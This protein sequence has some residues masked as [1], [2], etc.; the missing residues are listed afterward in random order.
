MIEGAAM[1]TWKRF[2]RPSNDGSMAYKGVVPHDC[3]SEPYMSRE[4]LRIE[5]NDGVVFWGYEKE[6]LLMATMGLQCVQDVGLIR[7]AH[8]RTKERNQGP[9]Y[10]AIM[11]PAGI[12]SRSNSDWHLGCGKLG[13]S[14][15]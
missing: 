9:R 2:G 15:L 7:H 13:N 14:L 3:W 10:P 11:A 8:V 5:I 1:E 4:E 12:R 6:G